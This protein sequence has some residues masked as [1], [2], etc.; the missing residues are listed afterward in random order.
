LGDVV[1]V[2]EGRLLLGAEVGSEVGSLVGVQ[3]E[4]FEVGDSELGSEVGSLVGVKEGF[5]VGDSELGSEV[6]FSVVGPV[7]GL[8]VG[9]EV[10]GVLEGLISQSIQLGTSSFHSPSLS[11][12]Y[13]IV[14]LQRP[15]HLTLGHL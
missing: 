10:R 5:E 14:P 13:S 6:G 12:R 15:I 2:T 11:H 8:I 4:G 9:S 7:V 3:E 1:G